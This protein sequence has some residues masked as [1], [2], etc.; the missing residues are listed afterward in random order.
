MDSAS[1]RPFPLHLRRLGDPPLLG[2]VPHRRRRSVETTSHGASHHGSLLGNVT[3]PSF[4]W[5]EIRFLNGEGLIEKT[6]RRLPHWQQDGKT[7]FVTFRL[8]DSVPVHVL[9]SWREEKQR[10]LEIHPKPW[11]ADTE[12]EYQRVFSGTMDRYLDQGFGSCRLARPDH[13]ATTASAIHYFDGSRYVMHAFVIMPN[14]VHVLLSLMDDH[15][16]AEVVGSWKRF[17]A[18]VINKTEGTLGAVWM[19]D[20]FDRLIRDWDHFINV[21][22]YI[23]RNPGKAKLPEGHFA[24][25]EAPWVRRL[26]GRT[27]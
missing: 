26:M 5:S 17:T 18:T 13:S 1:F 7:F 10:W 23:D 8:N 3:Q 4:Q 20:H 9:N 19:E 15:R 11:P 27:G 22:R 12:M 21:C 16:I 25:Y 2:V 6:R 14:H 24:T